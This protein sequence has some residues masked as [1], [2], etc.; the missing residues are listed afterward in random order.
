MHNNLPLEIKSLCAGFIS[1]PV[2]K[3]DDDEENKACQMTSS[4][5][6]NTGVGDICT[7]QTGRVSIITQDVS[8][9]INEASGWVEKT[10]T[11]SP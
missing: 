8:S 3:P 5:L 2:D 1:H 7:L 11:K 10:D 4:A 9:V 6:V